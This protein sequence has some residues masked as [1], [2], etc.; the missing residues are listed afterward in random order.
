[1]PVEFAAYTPVM[2]AAL[3]AGAFLAAAVVGAAG[4][5]DGLVLGAVWFHVFEPAAV[6]PLIVL[7]GLCLY[8]GTLIPIRRQLDFRHLPALAVG[9]VIGTPVGIWL[10]GVADPDVVKRVLGALLLGIAAVRLAA[11]GLGTVAAG[12]RAADA[13]VGGAA[14]LLGG[15]AGLG[16][17]LPTIWA[18]LR[19]WG[20]AAGR[21]AYQPFV[22]VVQLVAVA[23]FVA[24]GRMDAGVLVSG[25]V[26]AP[27]ALAGALVGVFVFRRLPASA[28]RRLVLALVGVSGLTLVV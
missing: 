13:A 17:V 10:L 18:E 4:F 24:A 2:I 9:G 25:A 27:A 5:G 6:V 21:G 3:A 11:P 15:F 22:V 7:Q 16:G 1:V 12:G 26:V 19:G 14:G 23:G 28:F 20:R 8:A